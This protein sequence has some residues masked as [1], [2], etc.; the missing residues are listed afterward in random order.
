MY[1]KTANVDKN[2]FRQAVTVYKD[3]NGLYPTGCTQ[4]IDCNKFQVVGVP[5][6]MSTDIEDPAGNG[7]PDRVVG[8]LM[9]TQANVTNRVQVQGIQV[10]TRG[11]L[12]IKPSDIALLEA[13]C[14][15]CCES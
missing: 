7:C 1:Q 8:G 9:V 6:D 13:N 4:K 11:L 5:F 15:G 14:N 10:S 3:E 2:I 12:Y